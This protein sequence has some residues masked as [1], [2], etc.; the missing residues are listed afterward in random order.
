MI[1]LV[2]KEKFAD[3]IK[4]ASN[5]PRLDVDFLYEVYEAVISGI[6]EMR[7]ISSMGINQLEIVAYIL[8]EYIY[9]TNVLTEEKFQEFKKDNNNIISMASITADKYLSLSLF[10]FQEKRVMDKYVPPISTLNLYLN[11]MLNIL[12]NFSK[13]EPVNTL[14]RDLLDKS[15]SISRC[16]LTLLLEGYVT[17][18]F[19]TWR[20][21]H[22]CEC[23]LVLLEK[24]GEPLIQLYLKHMQYGMAYKKVIKDKDQ[25]DEIFRVM[26][27]EM[28]AHNLKSKDM[29]KYIEYGW[30]YGIEE[31]NNDPSYKLNFKDGLE[32]IS[33]ITG[34]G[35]FY[36]LSSE[37]VHATP[38]L[39]Y[40]NR[41]YFY[42]VTLLSLYEAFFRLEQSFVNLLKNR[43]SEEHFQAYLT[44][45]GVYYKHLVELYTREK[46]IFIA[47]SK[48]KKEE[49]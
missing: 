18:A 14:V 44:M 28:A 37:I 21:L 22:E 41:Q 43:L 33:G 20:T 3:F 35:D 45:R 48:M 39:I 7:N 1:N 15:I 24:Y 47:N 30:L 25:L 17:E 36:N 46:A 42:Y 12:N 49:A 10:N 29:K 4:R 8:N 6:N 34:Y 2:A 5:Y 38:I 26:K 32:R 16:V 31:F 23:T 19:A 13:N 40:S 27:E 11:F 9:T